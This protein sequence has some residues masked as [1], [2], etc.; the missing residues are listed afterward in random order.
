[1]WNTFSVN[2][3]EKMWSK[4]YYYRWFFWN[5]QKN[6]FMRS[7]KVLM[8][9]WDI[10]TNTHTNIFIITH[11]HADT[12]MHIQVYIDMLS[13]SCI[14]VCIHTY[15]C[16][17]PCMYICMCM[18]PNYILIAVLCCSKVSWPWLWKHYVTY[19]ASASSPRNLVRQCL[20]HYFYRGV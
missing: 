3:F 5:S 17:K 4:I 7:S 2:N 8:C 12:Y 13:N 11:I 16:V 15:M 10:Y 18:N 1:M 19:W 6:H 9:V 20:S 14:Y